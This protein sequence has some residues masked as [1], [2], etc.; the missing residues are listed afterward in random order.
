MP[1]PPPNDDIPTQE[2]LLAEMAREEKAIIDQYNA[3]PA[4]TAREVK[5][6]FRDS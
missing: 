1:R 6:R 4:E 2:E 3:L 5:E